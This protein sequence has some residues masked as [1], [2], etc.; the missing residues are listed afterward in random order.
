MNMALVADMALNLQHSLSLNLR[1]SGKSSLKSWLDVKLIPQTN[2]VRDYICQIF[3]TWIT[4]KTSIE[5]I[6]VLSRINN[7]I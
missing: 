4:I 5:L 6:T 1:Q 3:L 7:R 2:K